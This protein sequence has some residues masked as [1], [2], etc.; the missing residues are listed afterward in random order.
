[1]RLAIVS[2]IHANLTALEAVLADMRETS[3]DMVLHGGD[4]AGSGSASAE[5]V[6]R[7]RELGWSGVFGNADEMLYAPE[8]L[9]EFAVAVPGLKAMFDA[10]EDI[11]STTREELGDERMAWLRSLPARLAVGSLAL[12]HASPGDAWRAPGPEA[13]AGELEAMYAVLDRPIAV[14]GHI[15]RPFVRRAGA[16]VVANSGSVSLSYDGDPRASYLLVDD[17]A[18]VIRRVEYDVELECGRMKER[19]IPHAGWVGAM[20]R[21]GRFQMP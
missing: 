9:S 11:A 17:L 2:D 18:P 3:P 19:G 7:I 13:A 12:V 20:L 15:H 10:V 14:Y 5:T 6:D 16:M 1:M 4:L 8:K 21:Q